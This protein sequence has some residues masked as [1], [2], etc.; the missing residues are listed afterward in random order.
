MPSTENTDYTPFLRS[1]AYPAM[2]TRRR[3][4]RKVLIAGSVFVALAVGAASFGFVAMNWWVDA[5][6]SAARAQVLAAATHRQRTAAGALSALNNVR[7]VSRVSTVKMITTTSR[8]PTV[9][10]AHTGA[11]ASNLIASEA[12]NRAEMAQSSQSTK[13]GPRPGRHFSPPTAAGVAALGGPSTPASNDSNQMTRHSD[14]SDG[15]PLAGLENDAS[16]E[17][18]APVASP[19]AEGGRHSHPQPMFGIDDRSALERPRPIAPPSQPMAAKPVQPTTLHN[20]SSTA[21][22]AHTDVQTLALRGSLSAAVLRGAV[23]R[24][25]PGLSACYASSAQQ[26][27]HNAFGR[28]QVDVL[29]D[30]IGHARRPRVTGANL[31][32]LEDCVSA[33]A[34]K[35]VTRA[36]DTGSVVAS[37]MV[38]YS[39]LEGARASR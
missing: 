10:R 21:L 18:P 38:N 7:T 37:L 5:Q 16:L 15:D 24:I 12:G 23:E 33:V 30:E 14:S 26:A 4:M 19:A 8:V 31:P 25:R 39:A 20:A 32:G 29:I 9:A 36:P 22:E 34:S 17:P 28:V 35:L 6:E 3:R 2:E 13:P 27:G 1:G 11:A